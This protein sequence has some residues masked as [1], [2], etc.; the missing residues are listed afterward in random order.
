M[1]MNLKN[2]IHIVLV[3][4]KVF[5]RIFVLLILH[6]WWPLWLVHLTV[7]YLNRWFNLRLITVILKVIIGI[8]IIQKEQKIL[9]NSPLCTNRIELG[10][11]G[12]QMIDFW[13]NIN[14]TINKYGYY[15]HLLKQSYHLFVNAKTNRMYNKMLLYHI[16]LPFQ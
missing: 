6:E 4:K 5:L 10:R 13:K 8:D 15:I 12:N 11:H 3:N 7:F 14:L 2:C 1:I 16:L 9:W